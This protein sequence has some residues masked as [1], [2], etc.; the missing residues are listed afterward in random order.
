MI[1]YVKNW[2]AAFLNSSSRLCLSYCANAHNEKK[3]KARSYLRVTLYRA[4]YYDNVKGV[5]KNISSVKH[6]LGMGK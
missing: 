6:A 1:G 4:Y 3:H 5:H 2:K